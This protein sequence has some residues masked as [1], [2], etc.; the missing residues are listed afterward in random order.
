MTDAFELAWRLL[1]EEVE[2]EPPADPTPPRASWWQRQKM[3][4]QARKNLSG[5]PMGIFAR[6]KAEREE[7]QRLDEQR[8]LEWQAQQQAQQDAEMAREYGHQDP[9]QMSLDSFFGHDVNTENK[10]EGQQLWEIE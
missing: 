9:A 2:E 8:K 4:N 6:I 5:Q 3:A 7:K 10:P 1:K